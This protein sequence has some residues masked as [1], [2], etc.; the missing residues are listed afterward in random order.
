MPEKFK[1]SPALQEVLGIEV[2]TLPRIMVALWQYVKVKKLQEHDDTSY[3]MCD[4]PLRKVFGAEKLKL[5]MVS[6]K[7]APHLSPPGPISLAHM[8]KL[9]GASPA[10]KTC[11]DVLVDVPLSSED[12]KSSFLAN[13]EKNEEIDTYDHTISSAM[14][15]I[16]EHYRRRAFFLGFSESPAEFIN[17][18]TASQARDLKLAAAAATDDDADKER[19]AEFYDQPWLVYSSLISCKYFCCKL[20]VCLI[21]HRM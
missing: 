6:E 19:R 20:C 8:I 10:G 9:S 21:L 5:S 4:P 2:E 7:I 12:D 15:K 16:R 3:I 13:L 1:L 11:L 14:E 18:L 17:Y